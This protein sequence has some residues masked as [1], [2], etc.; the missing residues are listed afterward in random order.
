[1]KIIKKISLKSSSAI[2][3]VGDRFEYEGKIL[4]VYDCTTCN[5]CYFNKKPLEECSKFPCFILPQR[6]SVM[7]KLIEY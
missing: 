5:D 7:Y 3:S 1:M 4:E 6:R 2:Y